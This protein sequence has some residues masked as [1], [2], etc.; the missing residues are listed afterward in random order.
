MPMLA[1]GCSEG[2]DPTDWHIRITNTHF[3]GPSGNPNYEAIECES[4]PKQG[5]AGG[6]LFTSDGYLAGVCNFAEPQGNRGLYASPASIYRILDR[7]NLAFLYTEPAPGEPELDELI[8]A[9]ADRVQEGNREEAE[10]IL[11]RLNELIDEHR[12][13]LQAALRSLDTTYARRRDE[14]MR[15]ASE[16]RPETSRE[17][18]P[19]GGIPV[20]GVDLTPDPPASPEVDARL[21][22]ILDEWHR[23][24]AVR[25]NLDVRFILRERDRKWGDDV[26]GTGRAVLTSEGWML[27]EVD[28]GP[29]PAR[30]LER[31]IRTDGAMHQFRSK[32]KT[33][34]VWP[35]SAEDR[36]RLPAILSL[37]FCWRLD[38]DGLKWR[39]RV[40]LVSDERP[41]ACLLRFTPLTPIGR[42]S[43]STAYVELDRSTY[44]PRRYVV[45]LPGGRSTKDFRVTEAHCDRPIPEETWRIPDDDH[46]QPLTR[47]EE[48]RP[49]ERWLSGLIKVDL[50]P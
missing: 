32:P 37:P 17:A 23:R 25:T 24:S 8:R 45:V 18:A 35:M 29:G 36:G 2:D 30:G 11:R 28:R 41:D 21:D 14:L 43:F 7:N 15:R 40:D 38:A 22:R 3:R 39:Y 26:S 31:I 49:L 50:V 48:G 44:L 47:W 19:S 20:P 5:R 10:R 46:P 42:E 33:H 6:G 13:R 27:F 12:K 9:A 1:I 16:R 34:I 4:A